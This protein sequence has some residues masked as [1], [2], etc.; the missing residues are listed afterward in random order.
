[1][2][3]IAAK[4]IDFL[5]PYGLLLRPS[6]E[7]QP[8]ERS[9]EII[10][11]HLP[12]TF[13]AYWLLT[14]VPFVG[15]FFYMLL[16]VPLSLRLNSPGTYTKD[17]REF[18]RELLRYYVVIMIGFGG[19]W[20]FVGHTFMA[21]KIATGIGWETGSPFQTELAF[22]TLGTAVAAHLAIWIRGH[23]ITAIVV[24]KSIFWYGAAY[25]HIL[26]AIKNQN[27]APLNNGTPLIGDLLF[28]TLLLALLYKAN[29]E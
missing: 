17:P 3:S 4:A 16:L 6:R 13:F 8:F 10:W 24:S 23:L 14:F 27:Y 1:M 12:Q 29:R 25:V 18:S 11:R 28:P 15:G 5:V 7:L 21:D 2:I 20:S 9:G 22:Y 26:D 19:V